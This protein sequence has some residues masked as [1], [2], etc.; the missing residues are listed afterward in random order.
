MGHSSAY[1]SWFNVQTFAWWVELVYLQSNS[2][3]IQFP[4]KDKLLLN[5][6]GMTLPIV[7]MLISVGVT[8]LEQVRF[9]LLQMVTVSRNSVI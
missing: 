1:L 4:L 9:F 2:G 5:L 6:G 3:S 8:V 7:V